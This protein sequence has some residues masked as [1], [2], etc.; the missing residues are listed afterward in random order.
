VA[1]RRTY[2]DKRRSGIP[3]IGNLPWG[4]HLCQFYSAQKDLLEIL[5]PYFKAGLEDNECCVW[6]ASEPLRLEE[7]EKAFKKAFRFF[8]SRVRKG[9]L[10][11]IAAG[12]WHAMGAKSGK[13]IVSTLDEA[14]HNGFDGLRFA[15]HASQQR[16]KGEEF[17]CYGADIIGYY[18][19]IGLFAYP[20][21]KFDAAGLME[22][23]NRHRYALVHSAGKWEVIEC[24]EARIV[25]DA[26]KRS[27]QKLQSLFQ[28]MSEGFAY[29]RIILDAAG[30]PCN[31]VFLE[32]NE[33]FE[34][35]TGLRAKAIIGKRVT[36]VLPGIESDPT[37]WIGKYGKVAVTGKPIQFESYSKQFDMWYSVSAF[38]PHK[39]FFAVTYTDISQRK[40][41][42]EQHRKAHDELERKVRERTE[43]L[44]TVNRTL[45]MISEC[46]QILVRVRNEQELMREICRIVVEIGGYRMAWVGYVEDDRDKTVRPVASVGFEEGYLERARISWADNERGCGPTGTCI[47][48]GAVC[49][50]R[51]FL[52]DPKLMPWRLEALKRGY[53]SSIALPLMSNGKA[54]GALMIYAGTLD[55]FNEDNIELLRELADDLAFG[56]VALRVQA[57]R[58]QSR[59]TAEK[60][61]EQLYALASELVQ[62]EQKER[63]RLAQILHDHI[64]QLLVAAKFNAEVIHME[65]KTEGIEEAASLLVDTLV[66]AIEASRSLSADLCPP[67]LHEKGLVAAMEWLRLQMLKKHRL[68]V[69]VEVDATAEP[70]TEQIRI[71]LFDAV[72]ELLLNVVKYAKVDRAMVRMKRTETGDIEVTVADRGTGFDAAQLE[73]ELQ[74]TGGFGLFSIRERLKY[75]GGHMAIDA[76]PG[77]GSKFTLVAPIRLIPGARSTGRPG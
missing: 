41:A 29:H 32:A 73:S 49:I 45:Q 22:V 67:V 17:T 47:R 6:I 25:K 37:D 23:V 35:L 5:V 24:S 76:A 8:A 27:E 38:S 63:R 9:Q 74:T 42:E 18:N 71:F 15:S 1:T 77:L 43:A 39:G 7:A 16:K 26:L 31:Y 21:K 68:E 36:E 12:R 66:E 4:T 13:A 20:R 75:F 59:L 44:S 72:R 61:A 50:G 33:A 57:E 3:Q 65:A 56:I 14:I 69:E 58:D 10:K 11:I 19:V 55:A 60:R 70:T 2:S 54:F 52:D 51:N 53:R 40:K 48:T 46:N 28:H 34:R 64:Q 30:K 62:A